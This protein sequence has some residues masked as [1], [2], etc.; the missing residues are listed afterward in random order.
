MSSGACRRPSR[1]RRE[2]EG[3]YGTSSQAHPH[4]QTPLRHPASVDERTLAPPTPPRP[5]AA[6]RPRAPR[7]MTCLTPWLAAPPPSPTGRYSLDC[8][9]AASRRRSLPPQ[10]R[11]PDSRPRTNLPRL[12]QGTVNHRHPHPPRPSPTAPEAPDRP[13][14]ATPPASGA[15]QRPTQPDDPP[16]ITPCSDPSSPATQPANAAEQHAEPRSEETTPTWSR[17]K[18]TRAPMD[19]RCTQQRQTQARTR[20]NRLTRRSRLAPGEPKSRVVEDAPRPATSDPPSLT[21][22]REAAQ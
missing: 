4:T 21:Q 2:R 14:T 1:R 22:P 7:N 17:R 5:A 15:A 6:R 10:P 13:T 3:A 12:P 8:A 16:S 20:Q 18:P 19:T 11:N 9:R